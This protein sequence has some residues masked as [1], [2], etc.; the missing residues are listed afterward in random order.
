MLKDARYK[1]IAVYETAMFVATNCFKGK[2]SYKTIYLLYI[3]FRPS[4]TYILPNQAC[5]NDNFE[6]GNNIARFQDL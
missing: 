6:S 2:A 4:G 1:L 5:S 3:L